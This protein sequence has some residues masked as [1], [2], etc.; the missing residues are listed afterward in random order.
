MRDV[1]DRIVRLEVAEVA[2]VAEAE[3]CQEGRSWD[4]SRWLGRLEVGVDER[5]GDR[6]RG[7]S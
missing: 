2:E 3:E 4:V 6:I 5:E 7:L 1:F